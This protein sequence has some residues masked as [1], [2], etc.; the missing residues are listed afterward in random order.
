MKLDYY[1]NQTAVTLGRK[2]K[3]ATC[4]LASSVHAILM[5]VQRIVEQRAEELREK[6]SGQHGDYQAAFKEYHAACK[7]K[8]EVEELAQKAKDLNNIASRTSG[9]SLNVAVR[10]RWNLLNCLEDSCGGFD[11]SHKMSR[12]SNRCLKPLECSCLMK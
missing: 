6:E 2:A 5:H 9:K 10:K 12:C 4:S 11:H 8:A 7:L 1:R 3:M